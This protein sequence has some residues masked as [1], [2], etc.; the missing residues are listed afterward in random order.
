[1]IELKFCFNHPSSSKV[2]RGCARK[3]AMSS[4][5]A[6]P[7]H[8]ANLMRVQPSKQDGGALPKLPI[9]SR[10]TYVFVTM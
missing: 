2:E 5:P 4:I 9:D 3:L 1:M 8:R 10:F 7:Q 6:P